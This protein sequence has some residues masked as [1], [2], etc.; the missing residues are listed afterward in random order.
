V[1][2]SVLFVCTGNVCRSPMAEYLLR[3]RLPADA[4]ITVSS[5]GTWALVGR[6]VDGPSA[7]ALREL[8]VDPAGHSA[9]RLTPADLDRADLVL[10]AQTAHRSEIVR[11]APLRFR[12]VFTMREFGRLGAGFPPL[13]A[14]DD[15]ALRD[16]VAAVAER[17]GHSDPPAPGADDVGDPFGAGPEIARAC[18]GQVSD[19]V[20]AVLGALGLQPVHDRPA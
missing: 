16:R 18:A 5:A 10:T 4:P 11:Q 12:S 3:A 15:V 17:R 19:A 6:A 14:V 2:F 9:R 1:T 8:G 20:D 13:D 7:L